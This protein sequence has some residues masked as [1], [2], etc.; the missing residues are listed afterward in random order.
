VSD[1]TYHIGAHEITADRL[2]PGLY[3]VATPI[4]NLGDITLRALSTLAAS[5]VIYCED[6]RITARLLDRYG[7]RVPLR[8]YHDHNEQKA[9]PGIVGELREGKVIAL[10]SD[11]GTPLISDPGYRLVSAVAATGLPITSLPGASAVLTAL[12]L[13][14]LATDR[15]CFIG[16]LPEKKSHRRGSLEEIA[17]LQMT[18]VAYESPHRLRDALDDI[19]EVMPTR[20]MAMARELTKLHEEVLRGTADQIIAALSARENIKGEVALVF[21]PAPE[22][23][24]TTDEATIENAITLALDDLPASKAAAQ[25]SKQLGLAKSDIYQRILNRK[26]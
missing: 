23:P 9:V 26:T 2:P 7:M 6:T 12:Q 19:A 17:R 11:A 21:A 4:G 3:L 16:F 15:F 24:A 8:A 5:D 20:V 13:S 1:R 25:V 14:G 18:A 22:E 10:V